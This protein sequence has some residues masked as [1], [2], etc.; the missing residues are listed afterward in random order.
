MDG[1]RKGDCTSSVF[2]PSIFYLLL[3]FFHFQHLNLQLTLYSR[4]SSSS[5]KIFIQYTYHWSYISLQYSF[6]RKD[7]KPWR[8][9]SQRPLECLSSSSP[10]ITLTGVRSYLRKGIR[11]KGRLQVILFIVQFND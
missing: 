2:F 5:S 9:Y 8:E 6:E 1:K 10:S 7:G 11:L 3:K 4:L